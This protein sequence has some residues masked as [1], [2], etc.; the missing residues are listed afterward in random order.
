MAN[1]ELKPRRTK[2]LDMRYHWT[3]QQVR[4]GNLIIKWIQGAD[5]LADFFTKALPVHLH[6]AFMNLFTVL[7]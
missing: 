1:D 3:R 4:D 2:A 7:L 5:N 6:L